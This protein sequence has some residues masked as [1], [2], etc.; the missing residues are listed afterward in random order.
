MASF[1]FSIAT[2]LAR[3]KHPTIDTGI[4][5]LFRALILLVA[6]FIL[7]NCFSTVKIP[8]FTT[9]LY[10]AAG[11]FLEVFITIL[12]AYMSLRYIE[13]YKTSITISTKGIFA[14]IGS[15]VFLGLLPD[16]YQITGGLISL[17][18]VFLVSKKK[19]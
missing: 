9:M 14:L 8:A 16:S 5:S 3:K 17:L 11:S 12:F 4:L 7:V 15:W 18:G 2:I 19:G 1:L 6:F 10:L 13:A